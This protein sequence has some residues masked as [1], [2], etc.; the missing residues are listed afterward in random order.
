M[1]TNLTLSLFSLLAIFSTSL[2]NAII[3]LK[4]DKEILESIKNSK[5]LSGK[6]I[7]ISIS[8]N[9]PDVPCM[10]L[11]DQFQF[12]GPYAEWLKQL[13]ADDVKT[14][15]SKPLIELFNKSS[16]GVKPL[17][18]VSSD[19]AKKLSYVELADLYEILGNKVPTFQRTSPWLKCPHDLIIAWQKKMQQQMKHNEMP[20]IIFTTGNVQHSTD[21][22]PD[23]ATWNMLT[24][25]MKGICFFN[26]Q[27]K[28]DDI[29]NTIR[30][31]SFDKEF[32]KTP[33]MD[34]A[35]MIG[36]LIYLFPQGVV[37]SPDTG[38]L[39]L[40][41]SLAEGSKEGKDRVWCPLLQN[42]DQR[43]KGN[44]TTP[45]SKEENGVIKKR[46]SWYPTSVVI[47]QQTNGNYKPVISKMKTDLQA[48]IHQKSK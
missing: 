10:G 24:D 15:A 42:P 43:W 7:V 1:K 37:I 35:A 3:T 26:C 5:D 22:F 40:A 13:G 33:F 47:Y 44:Y 34:T 6:K 31:S 12:V 14:I 30:P 16:T 45:I 32:D 46:C 20:V 19:E 18:A 11:G 2:I 23:K 17:P 8:K 38:S 39:H 48:I 41:A 27:F 28:G 21:R 36:A 25:N 9:F 4:E 29:E